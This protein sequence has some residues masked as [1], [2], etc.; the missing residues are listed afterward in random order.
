MDYKF[1]IFYEE[2]IGNISQ[3]KKILCIKRPGK[4]IGKEKNKLISVFYHLY[5]NFITILYLLSAN[6]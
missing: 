4:K 6:L 2:D 3:N 1:Y 5:Y